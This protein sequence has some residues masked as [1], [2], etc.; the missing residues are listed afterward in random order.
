M[1]R[2]LRPGGRLVIGEI[3]YW[4]LWAARR[5]FALARHPIWRG[6]RFRTARELRALTQAARLTAIKTR[7]A[8]YS[9]VAPQPAWMLCLRSTKLAFVDR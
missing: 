7:R 4:S 6:A 5:H 2:V 8:I 1:T 9:A 3:G